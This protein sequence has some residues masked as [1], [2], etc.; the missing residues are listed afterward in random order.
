M[1]LPKVMRQS[2]IPLLA[3]LFGEEKII[4]GKLPTPMV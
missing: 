4:L 3:K 2:A 1:R